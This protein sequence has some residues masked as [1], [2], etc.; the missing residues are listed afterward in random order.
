MRHIPSWL[1]LSATIIFGVTFF[2]GVPPT[3][4]AANLLPNGG[5]E[6]ADPANASRP[7]GW[8]AGR[9]GTNTTS[10][11]YPDSGVGGSRAAGINMSARTS[12]DAKWTTA[13][14]PIRP[15][16]VYEYSDS[17][18]STVTTHVTVEITLSNGTIQY[19]DIGNPGAASSWTTARFRFAAPSTAQ[20][21][22]IFHLINQAGTLKIDNANLVEVVTDEP[23]A[24]DPDNLIKNASLESVDTNNQ[25]LNWFKGRWG[26]NT[27]SFTFPISAQHGSKAARVQ[28]TS[29]SSGDA[30]WY[31]QEVPVSAGAAYEFSS[32]SKGTIT[33]YITVRF[34]KSD[35]SFSY[36]DVGT[37]APSS[38]WSQFKTTFTV[39]VGTV[40]LTVF[41]VIKGSGTLDIDNYVLKRITS[42]S[43]VFD[44]GYVS[45][46]FDDG[47]LSA[48]QNAVPILNA[49]GFKSNQYIVTDYLTSNYPGYVKPV[50]VLDMQSDGH[51]IDAHTRSHPNLTTLTS[52]Q[53]QAEIAGSRQ[54]LLDLGATPVSAF[55]YP[56]G[57]YNSSVQQQVRNA[58]FIGARSSNGGYN[59]KRTDKYALR[60][61]SMENTTTLAKIK[62]DIDAA[63]M[64]KRWVIL[65]FHEVNTSGHRYSVT[66]AM[67]QQ[68][69]DYLKQKGVTPITIQQGLSKMAQ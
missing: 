3:Q 46:T 16:I 6:T 28:M 14:V 55:A 20:S 47:W 42:D 4:A 26:T 13:P 68:I 8:V 33:T 64:E 2:A 52:S 19:I 18:I 66:P 58:G 35:G 1:R 10:F 60:R 39:P 44:K 69:V 45:L 31:F 53:Q 61:V 67:F 11:I 65:L 5:F 62:A 15:G 21:A 41:H 57:A 9:W 7:Q 43:T 36:L 27:T 25:P 23:P 30:K 51:V 56:L 49:A 37:R 50:H 17:Y 54:D 59:D 29:W 40:S 48:Y 24:P 12:G 34:K 63:L 38:S 32:Y 22:R